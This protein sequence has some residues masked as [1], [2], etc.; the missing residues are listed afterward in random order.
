MTGKK[1]ETESGQLIKRL[2]EEVRAWC[3]RKG[4]R[5]ADDHTLPDAL[6]R[7]FGDEMALLTSEIS[8]ALEAYRANGTEE[9][10]V[11]QPV[12]GG[13]KM[14]KMNFVQV[15]ALWSVLYPESTLGDIPWDELNP[16]REG[17]GPEL[18]GLFV[19][20]LDTSEH[21]GVNLFD[22]YRKEMDYNESREF[23]H[24]NKGL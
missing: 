14:P 11:W 5:Q 13:I 7:T 1:V 12:I 2:Q 20:L 3:E 24:G 8:E 21:L 15:T 17:V 16:R 19:R 6:G 22:E 9:W 18:A 23:R 10:T 4:W